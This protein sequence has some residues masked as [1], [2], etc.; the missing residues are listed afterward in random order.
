MM[1]KEP[2]NPVLLK[3]YGW[4]AYIVAAILVYF[5]VFGHLSDLPIRIWDESRTAINAYEMFEN[6]NWLVTHSDGEPD[7]WN[8]KPPL[9]IWFQVIFMKILG[10]NEL[11]VRMPSA[12]AAFFTCIAMVLF[13]VKHFRQ[14]WLG[15]FAALVLITS[16]GYTGF[17]GSRSGDYDTLLTLFTTAYS[18]CFF[19]YIERK[20]NKF[21]FLTFVFLTLACLTKGIAGMFFIPGLFIYSLIRRQLISVLRNPHFYYGIASFILPVAAYYLF[22]EKYN[23]GY[24]EAVWNNEIS[25][26][27][28]DTYESHY[29]PFWYYLELIVKGKYKFWRFVFPFGLVLGLLNRNLNIKRIT[30]YSSVL[31]LMHFLLISSFET[32]TRWYDIP[33]YPYMAFI[34]AAGIYTVFEWIKNLEVIRTVRYFNILPYLFLFTAFAYPY[35][36][37]LDETLPPKEHPW[38]LNSY[39][40]S[41]F[42]R[43]ALREGT[44]LDG[45]HIVHQ[46]YNS[47]LLFYVKLLQERGD[48]IDFKPVELLENNDLV[49][50]HQDEVKDYISDHYAYKIIQTNEN[51]QIL[52]I[53]GREESP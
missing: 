1:V 38:D 37:T 19:L 16:N 25:G 8:T 49:I 28:N 32:K 35:K 36:L 9:M 43:D 30:L 33:M 10:V 27:L 13:S 26:R 40:T 29:G 3:N 39:R 47:H 52:E 34:S 5:P 23:P 50:I 51:M 42:L 17:H 24:L 31:I 22:R 18:M 53:L 44:D 45:Y 21:L 11:A 41:Y 48:D 2:G 15:I 6:G 46:R 4:I 7:M 12:L 14:V 20:D